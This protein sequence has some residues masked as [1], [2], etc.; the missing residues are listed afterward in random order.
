M[1]R[2]RTLLILL[3]LAGP[4]GAQE[5]ATDPDPVLQSADEWMRENLDDEVVQA[6]DRVLDR[7]RIRVFLA[8]LQRRFTNTSVYELAALKDSASRWLPVLEQFEE[9]QPYAAWL[10]AHLDYLDAAEQMSR[11]VRAP[12]AKPPT[13][14]PPPAPS[15]GLQQSV[16]T[17]ELAQRPLPPFARD[18]VPRLKPLF[19][20]EKTPP[21]LV[22]VAEVE[23][24]FNPAARS[25]AGAA[26]LFQLTPPT[27][28]RFGLS[29][30][31][32][33]ERLHPEKSAR[34]AARYLHRLH[35]RYGDW[36]LA[37]AAYNAGESRVD[38]LLR[39]SK[40]RSYDAIAGRLPAETQMYVP[41]CEATLRKREGLGLADLKTPKG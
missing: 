14:T 6:L 19:A 7:D 18:H 17:R 8:D 11:E 10:Q 9:T 26:G 27:A 39:K 24:S 23:S 32:P 30:W 40:R 29:T 12:P 41:K 21:E 4:A 31:W 36:R 34:V 3:A 25:P 22:W 2:F 13:P 38:A 15:P 35:A 5:P 37:L 28:K 33:D 16:W 20:A 1:N